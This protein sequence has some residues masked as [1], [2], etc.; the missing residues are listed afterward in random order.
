MMPPRIIWLRVIVSLPAPF[1]AAAA[2]ML[3]GR[4]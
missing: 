1:L 2:A 3:A 4:P